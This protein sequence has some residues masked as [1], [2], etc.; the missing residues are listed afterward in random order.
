MDET[1]AI[2]KHSPEKSLTHLAQETWVQKVLAHCH[3]THHNR[4]H[5]RKQK[6][7]TCNHVIPLTG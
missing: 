7:M 2:S 3:K 1:G 6:C 5:F 4:N